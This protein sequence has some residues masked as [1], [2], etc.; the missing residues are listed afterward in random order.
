[1]LTVRIIEIG[2]KSGPNSQQVKSQGEKL[3]RR[4]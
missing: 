1:M 3:R 2:H 4:S